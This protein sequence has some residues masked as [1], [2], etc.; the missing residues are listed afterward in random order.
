MMIHETEFKWDGTLL[1]R[2]FTKGIVLHHRAGCG[3]V[4]SIH[5]E[6][7]KN[8]WSGIGYHFY[9]RS[10]GTIYRG[11]PIDNIGAHAQGHNTYTVGI[12]FE[13]NFENEEMSAKQIKSGKWLI[14]YIE[15]LYGEAL[16]IKKHSELGN[17]ACPGKFFPFSEM[18]A[19]SKDE[20]VKKM[21]LDGVIS[22]E[23]VR[24]WELFLSGKAKPD[25]KWVR[26]IIERYQKL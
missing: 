18:T 21:Y 1:K 16:S 7:L 8:G 12:C 4:L 25:Y 3:D 24:N 9:V 22:I 13:G 14:A 11:R 23:N 20:I 2:P 10:D 5:N 17:T 15:G 26:T 6:H 19:V